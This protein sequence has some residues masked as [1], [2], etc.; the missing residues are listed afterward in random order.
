MT[1]EQTQDFVDLPEKHDP[2]IGQRLIYKPTGQEFT[3]L[4]SCPHSQPRHFTRRAILGDR[5]M[6]ALPINKTKE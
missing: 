4:C 1:D 6:Y 2:V 3:V 5:S